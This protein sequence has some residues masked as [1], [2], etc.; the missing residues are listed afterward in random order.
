MIAFID[1]HR[2]VLR[3]RAD[4]Q[5]AAIAPRPTTRTRARRAV[6]EKQPA[7]ARSDAVLMVEI[8]RVHEENFGVYGVRKVWRQ[9]APRGGSWPP[10]CTVAR[11]MRTMGLAGVVRGTDGPHHH[12]RSSGG[13][14]LSTASIVSSGAAPERLVGGGLHV[15]GHLRAASST[16]RLSSS[17]RSPAGSSA[18]GCVAHRARSFVL[19]ALEQAL[20]E[21]RL[22]SG[23]GS[24]ITRIVGSQLP[25]SAVYT[26]GWRRPACS[27]P[28][29]SVGGLV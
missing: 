13:F 28:V 1:D 2:E 10:R 18:G 20:H 12:P 26:T 22:C 16:S 19:D 25:R 5:G 23:A 15:R 24:C 27:P 6:P 4:L 9:L 8:R 3:G 29:G 21:R 11:L 17:M 14:A 7:R